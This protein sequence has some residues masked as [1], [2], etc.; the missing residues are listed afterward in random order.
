MTSALGLRDEAWLAARTRLMPSGCIEWTK[1]RTPDG[2]GDFSFITPDRKRGHGLANR[3]ALELRL[4]RPLRPGMC[5]LHTC[6]NPP[7]CNAEH[8]FEGTRADNNL[9]RARKGRSGDT[10]G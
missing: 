10:S 5:A 3:L 4:G 6:D 2:Y 9:D 1:G 7:C 8:L